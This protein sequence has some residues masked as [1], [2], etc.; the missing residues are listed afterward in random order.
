M[1]RRVMMAGASGPP[2]GSF[3]VIEDITTSY[4]DPA[5][6]AISV[7]YPAVVNAGDL[8]LVLAGGSSAANRRFDV[9][10]GWTE[11]Y[12]TGNSTSPQSLYSMIAAGTE[13]GGSLNIPFLSNT[14]TA[15]AIMIRI[16]AG[17]HQ[18]AV[19]AAP[20]DGSSSSPAPVTLTPTWGSASTKWIAAMTGRGVEGVS[21]YPMAGGN[22]YI[23]TPIATGTAGAQAAVCWQDLAAPSISPGAFSLNTARPW[24][25]LTI[26]I[27]PA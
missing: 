24:R 4:L 9:P 14:A 22:T 12:R 16:R 19:E 11:V 7:A 25:T 2:P 5:D 17:T 1:L 20:N 13:G 10:S 23:N 21:S 8:L 6:A 3:P 15:V 26:G 18:G 27:R